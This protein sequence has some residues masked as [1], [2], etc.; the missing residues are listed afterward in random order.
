MH[1]EENTIVQLC[2][3][4]K[5][6]II[7]KKGKWREGKWKFSTPFFLISLSIYQ[8]VLVLLSFFSPSNPIPKFNIFAAMSYAVNIIR[9]NYM[10]H[11]YSIWNGVERKKRR[12]WGWA[13]SR[14]K[15]VLQSIYF[16]R[17]CF[18]AVCIHPCGEFLSK[19]SSQFKMFLRAL[20]IGKFSQQKTPPSCSS[21]IMQKK[22]KTNLRKV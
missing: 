13:R 19:I 20:R 3:S 9:E 2:Y 15:D 16:S 14:R 5:S 22:N 1:K 6:R 10:F 7:V 18:R 11:L 21:I 8:L 4:K 17:P 12:R